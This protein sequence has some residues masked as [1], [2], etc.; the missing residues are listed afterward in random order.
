MKT[1]LAELAI[2]GGPPAFVEPLHVG[3]PN[4]GDRARFLE[5]VGEMLDRRW[6]T[7]DG[8]F[9]KEF[10][11]RVA[12]LLG[13]RHCVATCNG[14]L[15]LELTIRA[16]G[17]R[18]EV[19]VP[20]FTFVATAHALQWHGIRPVF[21]DVDPRTHT[22]DPEQVERAVT[23]QTS[24]ILGV[25]VWGRPCAVD[26][27]TAIAKK[28]RLRLV[29]DSAHAFACSYQGTL[30][31]RFGDA[32][33]LSFHATK[34]FHTV[35]GGAVVTNDEDLAQRLR[36]MRNFGFAGYDTVL[37]LGINGKMN[38]MCAAMGLSNLEQLDDIISTNLRN[39]THYRR[40]LANVPGVSLVTYD[41]R[42]RCNYQYIVL[43]VDEG[44]A[45]LERDDLL[46]VLRAENVLARRYFY[47]GVHRMEPYRTLYPQPPLPGTQLLAARVLSLPTGASISP[48]D[49][50]AVCGIIALAVTHAAEV[51]AAVQRR[52]TAMGHSAD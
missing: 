23:P 5:R 1:T 16:L 33:I 36:L 19:I 30:L 38:E 47:P 50:N 12:A 42:E 28:H 11:G 6:L 22:L 17:L 44:R 49:I 4:I 46:E 35:E 41:A 13:V 2:L 25:H 7:N 48:D 26:A 20:S 18:G 10:E 21:A 34:F 32:E 27:L 31:G 39:Y 24:A 37:T 8:P 14:T 43:E 51:R 3:R 15:A 45:G 40:G 9:V 29:F 52:R